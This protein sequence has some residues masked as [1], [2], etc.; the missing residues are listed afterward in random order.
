MFTFPS[1]MGTIYRQEKVSDGA[2]GPWQTLE[3]PRVPLLKLCLL[4]VGGRAGSKHKVFF[5]ASGFIVKTHL[6][7]SLVSLTCSC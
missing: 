1:G 3:I 5:E 7:F 2:A 6:N 4:E